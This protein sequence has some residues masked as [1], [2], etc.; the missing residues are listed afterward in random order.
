VSEVFGL[1]SG[2]FILIRAMSVVLA[3]A[4]NGRKLVCRE[5]ASQCRLVLEKDRQERLLEIALLRVLKGKSF[6]HNGATTQ[7]I[8]S[9]ILLQSSAIPRRD[10]MI[11]R[12]SSY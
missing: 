12:V 8:S 10:L 11:Q 2:L 3:N 6:R 1:C 5:G 7:I 9:L 4:V